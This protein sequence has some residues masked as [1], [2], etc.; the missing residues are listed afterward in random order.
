LE[1]R[2]EW[3]SLFTPHPDGKTLVCSDQ[4]KSH[5]VMERIRFLVYRIELRLHP[6]REKHAKLIDLLK[7]VPAPP[8]NKKLSSEIMAVTQAILSEEWNRAARGR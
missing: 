7:Q 6:N 8:D 3:A 5:E 2:I 4:G 1:K